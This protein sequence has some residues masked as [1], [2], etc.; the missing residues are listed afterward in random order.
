MQRNHKTLMTFFCSGTKRLL[1]FLTFSFST[2]GE[3]ETQFLLC[4]LFLHHPQ[5]T[6]QL[7][8]LAQSPISTNWPNKRAAHSVALSWTA[9]AQVQ[10]STDVFFSKITKIPSPSFPGLK[11]FTPQSYFPSGVFMMTFM[12]TCTKSWTVQSLNKPNDKI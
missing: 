1:I 8:S 6:P 9:L 2:R 5:S 12:N 10:N 3:R 11:S 7:N 4:W